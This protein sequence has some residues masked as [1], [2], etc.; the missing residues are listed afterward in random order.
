[1]TNLTKIE[2]FDG[3]ITWLAVANR[4]VRITSEGGSVSHMTKAAIQ[5]RIREMEAKSDLR[6]SS[7][8]TLVFLKKAA[9]FAVSSGL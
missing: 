8:E 6:P 4:K 2:N 1:M 9:E 5:K 7:V 3:S